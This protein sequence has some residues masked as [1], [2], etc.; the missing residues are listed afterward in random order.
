MATLLPLPAPPAQKGFKGTEGGNA[1]SGTGAEEVAE[2]PHESKTGTRGKTAKNPASAFFIA[3]LPK[4]IIYCHYIDDISIKPL[5]SIAS[6]NYGC[7]AKTTALRGH[8]DPA[9]FRPG[10]CIAKPGLPRF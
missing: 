2:D 10:L 5:V 8:D 6:E 9:P 7:P 4:I 1:V 3:L